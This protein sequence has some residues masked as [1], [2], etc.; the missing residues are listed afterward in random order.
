MDAE[1]TSR[2][3]LRGQ[4]LGCPLWMRAIICSRGGAPD[5]EALLANVEVEVPLLLV[6]QEGAEV[7]AC[8]TVSGRGG[9]GE[10]VVVLCFMLLPLRH[11]KE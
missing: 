10:G 8:S 5:Q 6:S 9:A 4:L 3:R 1:E 2:E 7:A 11:K